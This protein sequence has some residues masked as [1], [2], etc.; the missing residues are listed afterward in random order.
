MSTYVSR[1]RGAS[2]ATVAAS[3]LMVLTMIYV[4]APQGS[5][6]AD[7]FTPE[8]STPSISSPSLSAT[9][10]PDA[11]ASDTEYSYSVQ[12][13]DNDTLAD[14]STVSVCLYHS[15]EGDSG[16]SSLNPAN[17]VKLLWTGSTG[18]F[19][20][21]DGTG[22]YW[23]LGTATAPTSLGDTAG[24]FTFPFKVSEATRQGTWTAAV[25]VQDGSNATA[26]DSTPT[27][28]VN[29]YAA[30]TARASVDFGT[31]AADT[32]N[33]VAANPT[34]TS[35]GP[36]DYS[37]TAGDFSGPSESSFTL[38]TTGAAGDT[39]RNAGEVTFDCSLGASYDTANDVRVGASATSLGTVT[40]T[41]TAEDG[42]TQSN[43]CQVVHGGGKPIGTY[44]FGVI[45]SVAAGS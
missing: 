33:P 35:N 8:N 20:I 37:M 29:H 6:G 1:V 26:T 42:E 28:T 22:S 18:Q 3:L 9:I 7:S 19:S 21:D 31:L 41:G 36:T 40:S 38:V 16:C 4:L 34:V 25:T 10:S 27:S 44:T 5:A 13:T 32:P 39:A 45:N 24:T 30:I 17:T 23:T 12:V 43:T 14:L 15:S 2:G 11:G